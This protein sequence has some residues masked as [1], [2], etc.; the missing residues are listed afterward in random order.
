MDYIF[1]RIYLYYLKKDDIPV[2]RTIVFLTITLITIIFFLIGALNYFTGDFFRVTKCNS[3]EYKLI[4]RS[5]YILFVLISI[6]RYG[7]KKKRE[8]IFKKYEG[9]EFL[10]T[11][12]YFMIPLVFLFLGLFVMSL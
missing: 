4:T 7:F 10:K 12:V 9:V 3:L 1:Y 2:V 11:W 5:I 8:E 6:L